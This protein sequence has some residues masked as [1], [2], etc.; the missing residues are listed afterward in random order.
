LT[1]SGVSFES[2]DLAARGRYGIVNSAPLG[3]IDSTQ[4]ALC[5]E[6]HAKSGERVH[7]AVTTRFDKTSCI[8]HGPNIVVVGGLESMQAKSSVIGRSTRTEEAQATEVVRETGPSRAPSRVALNQRQRRKN[9]I[10]TLPRPSAAKAG[11]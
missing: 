1:L 9:Y 10:N 8:V 4:S 7:R 3:V 6:S 5:V 11:H 2:R